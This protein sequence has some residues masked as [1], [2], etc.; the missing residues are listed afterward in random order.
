MAR[1]YAVR[2][3]NGKRILLALTCDEDGC[4]AEIKPNPEISRSGWTK[5]GLTT[6]READERYYCPEHSWGKS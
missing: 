5:T 2:E 4:T 1:I 3:D 6:G